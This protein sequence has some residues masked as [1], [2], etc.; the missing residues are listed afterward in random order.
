[1]LSA[2][3]GCEWKRFV[4]V[5]PKSEKNPP[6]A[7]RSST[8][9]PG[10]N[11]ALKLFEQKLNQVVPVSG[12]AGGRLGPVCVR[13][14]NQRS[15][16]KRRV[17]DGTCPGMQKY[18]S[19]DPPVPG[20]GGNGGERVRVQRRLSSK[21]FC[22]FGTGGEEGEGGGGRGASTKK[23]LGICVRSWKEILTPATGTDWTPAL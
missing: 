10:E 1:M 14:W 19:V 20:G 8:S 5:N 22:L 12:S 21:D 6:S 15:K 13:A 18:H 2:D 3:H 16:G 17:E 4:C 9:V 11:S 7:Q 23:I